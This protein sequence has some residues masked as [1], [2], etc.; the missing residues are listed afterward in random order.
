MFFF[1]CFN[2]TRNTKSTI[3]GNGINVCMFF[4][5]VNCF[6]YLLFC[7]DPTRS[8][9]LFYKIY[10]GGFAMSYLINNGTR[11]GVSYLFLS[12]IKIVCYWVA[13]ASLYD[14]YLWQ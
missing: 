8:V 1:F 2:E 13:S 5:E 12:C 10:D 6:L 9:G 11:C 14:V 7:R 4:D 3:C